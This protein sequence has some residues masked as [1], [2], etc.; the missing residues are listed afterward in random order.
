MSRV[1]R[2]LPPSSSSVPSL[3]PSGYQKSP[4]TVQRFPSCWLGRRSTWGM[5][6][7]RLRGSPRS[8]RSQSQWRRVRS[9]LMSWGQSSTSSAQRWRK[10]AWRMCLMRQSSLLLSLQLQSP[11]LRENASSC[12]SRRHTCTCRGGLV[13]YSFLSK[14]M[15]SISQSH[16]DTISFLPLSVIYILCLWY[17]AIIMCTHW[18]YYTDWMGW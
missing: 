13:C 3:P 6:L 7:P 14:F 2:P 16:L 8:S 12:R 18:E 15:V 5:M 11:L 17:W 9:S 1:H 10:R 4:I